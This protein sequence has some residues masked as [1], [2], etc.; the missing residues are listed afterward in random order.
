[1]EYIN[2]KLTDDPTEEERKSTDGLYVCKL[3]AEGKARITGAYETDASGN[4]VSVIGGGS[5]NGSFY[6]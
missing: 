6:P 1:M 2:F 5:G 4:V 3:V